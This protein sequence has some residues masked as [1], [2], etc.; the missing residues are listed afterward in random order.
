[1]I[2]DHHNEDQEAQMFGGAIGKWLYRELINVG[3]DMG[4]C[5]LI[6]LLSVTTLTNKGL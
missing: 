3:I 5:Y 2:G 6:R 4:K 1:M